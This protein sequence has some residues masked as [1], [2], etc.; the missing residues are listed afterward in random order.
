MTNTDSPHRTADD[1]SNQA[2]IRAWVCPDCSEPFRYRNDCASHLAR[3]ACDAKLVAS[4]RW[5]RA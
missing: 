3:S 5:P 2:P 1:A 4:P